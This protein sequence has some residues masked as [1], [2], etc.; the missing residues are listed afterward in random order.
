[1]RDDIK[2]M[3]SRLGFFLPRQ[4]WTQTRSLASAAWHGG[5]PKGGGR[6]YDVIIVGNGAFGSSAAY[7]LS[8]QGARVLSLDMHPV[9]H[10]WGSSH[11]HTRII[12]LAYF[13]VCII[14]YRCLL[15]H[16]G[17]RTVVDSLYR[18]DLRMVLL[19]EAMQ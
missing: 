1:M 3:P 6:R 9:G 16:V 19:H 4:I 7:H 5:G 12:R 2:M 18:L 15:V 17:M 8:L 10:E 14:I 13:E 11:G